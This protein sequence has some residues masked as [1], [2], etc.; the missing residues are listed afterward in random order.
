M[1]AWLRDN[2]GWL[3]AATLCAAYFGCYV[4]AARERRSAPSS[5]R[6]K[7]EKDC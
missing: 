4:L 5:G 7:P 2:W 3:V 1:L 6:A